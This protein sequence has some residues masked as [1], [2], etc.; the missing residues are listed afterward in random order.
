MKN[1]LT[2]VLL[3]KWR[4]KQGELVIMSYSGAWRKHEWP[5][6]PHFGLKMGNTII[7]YKADN[8]RLPLHK[9]LNFG[10]KIVRKKL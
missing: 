8:L 10:G 5:V 2:I 4:L 9:M 3:A 7:H 1:C 6:I